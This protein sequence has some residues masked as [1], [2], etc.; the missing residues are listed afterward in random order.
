MPGYWEIEPSVFVGIL[1][2]EMVPFHWACGY[3]KLKWPGPFQDAYPVAGRPFDHAR[4]EICMRFLESGADHLFFL[5]SDVVLPEDAVHRLLRHNL[6]FVSAMYCRRSPPH[7]VPVMMRDGQWV[8]E[9]PS[10]TENPL[11]EVQLVGAGAMLIRRDVIANFPPQREGKHWFDWRVDLPPSQQFPS[12]SEDFTMCIE[13]KRRM[14]IPIMVDTS[15]R[16][17][18]IGL[19]ETDYRMA[20]PVGSTPAYRRAA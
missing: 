9:I 7:S 4:N 14:G 18:H 17:K 13:L 15:L 3:R 12:L 5:D 11:V 19:F 6:P 16:A 8:T 10:D 1:H 2:T 20:G